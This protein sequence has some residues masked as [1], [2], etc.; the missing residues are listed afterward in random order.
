MSNVQLSHSTPDG[1][2]MP[3]IV[4]AM[5]SF[6]ELAALAADLSALTIVHSVSGKNGSRQNASSTPLTLT[7]GIEQVRQGE[8]PALQVAYEFDGH[9]WTDT[10]FRLPQG[11][12]LVRCQHSHPF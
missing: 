11:V 5:L 12:R 10:L 9:T 1:P 4:Q 8:L 3:E 2:P 7:Q 6:E